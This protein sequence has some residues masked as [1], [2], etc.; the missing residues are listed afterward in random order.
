MGLPPLG[1]MKQLPLPAETK[2]SLQ[3][4]V[5]EGPEALPSCSNYYWVFSCLCEAQA[6][7]INH[8]FLFYRWKTSPG[9]KEIKQ[10]A[11]TISASH[12]QN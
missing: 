8:I 7:N 4:A 3:G 2:I 1:I 10:I 5:P 12:C 9:I 11:W 6:L